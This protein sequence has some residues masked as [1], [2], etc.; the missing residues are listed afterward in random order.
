[1]KKYKIIETMATYAG[2]LYKDDL[3]TFLNEEKNGDYRV[4]DG[5]G[6]IW[7]VEP[8]NLKLHEVSRKNG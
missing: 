5:M 2:T 6:K 7:F 1:M 8:Y 4:K 3:V